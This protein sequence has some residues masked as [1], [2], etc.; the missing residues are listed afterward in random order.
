[1][2]G[3]CEGGNEPPK[4]LKSHLIGRRRPNI[5]PSG[6]LRYSVH[7]AQAASAQGQSYVLRKWSH[8]MAKRRTKKLRHV[9]ANDIKRITENKKDKS[10]KRREE[11]R[12]EEKRREE[13][14]RE[15]KRREEKRR[16]EKR[17]EEKRREEKR[18]EEKM[19]DMKYHI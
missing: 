11:K 9:E 8:R 3:L 16:E 19:K 17:R 18:R 6:L 1:M 2:A 7:K 13:K 10:E 15:E 4:R 14:R 5:R 12:R